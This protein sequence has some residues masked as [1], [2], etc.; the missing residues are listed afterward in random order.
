[1]GNVFFPFVY[2]SK[3]DKKDFWKLSKSNKKMRE[4]RLLA[5]TILC[6]MDSTDPHS[7]VSFFFF[8]LDRRMNAKHSFDW[9]LGLA[10]IFFFITFFSYEKKV[11]LC[12]SNFHIYIKMLIIRFSFF[13]QGFIIPT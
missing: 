11:K 12:L 9:G 3:F 2:I 8:S 1:M 5:S 4:C 6:F 13:V 7:R 10:P